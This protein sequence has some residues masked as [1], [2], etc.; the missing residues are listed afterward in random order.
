MKIK[1][2][3]EHK[4]SLYEAL[5]RDLTEFEKNFLFIAAG[6][7][8]FSITFIKEIVKLDTSHFLF[9]LFLSWALIIGAIGVMMFT[10]L[11]SS[12]ASDDLWKAA[13]DFIQQHKLYDDEIE[14]TDQQCDEIKTTLS[15][16]RYPVKD[17]LRTN[18]QIAIWLFLVGLVSL[19]I[20][21]GINIFKEKQGA[22]WFGDPSKT[23]KTLNI[24]S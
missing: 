19:S 14:M 18:R 20:Y 1:A 12:K 21:V 23:I 5:C 7:L 16:I 2:L 22:H 10:F 15:K 8:A 24:K 6:I 13:D 11:K 3:N 4:K 17:Q 9:L